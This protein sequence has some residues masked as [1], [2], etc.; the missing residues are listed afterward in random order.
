MKK[1]CE[2]PRCGVEYEIADERSDSGTCSFTCWEELNCHEPEKI[3][4]E[5]LEVE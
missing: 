5:L 1:R 4:F 3:S 2:N